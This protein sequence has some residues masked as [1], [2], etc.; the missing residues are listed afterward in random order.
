MWRKRLQ[1]AIDKNI[2][3][4]QGI[5]L[6]RYPSFILSN[7]PCGLDRIPVFV[8]HDVTVGTLE[9]MLQFLADNHYVTL[10]ADEY[11]ERQIRG[12]K[13][14][15]REVV[16]TFDD[17]HKSLY[18]VAFPALKRFGFK[19]VAYIVPGL[20]EEIDDPED[21]DKEG[22]PLCN[23][24]EIKEMHDS[25]VVDIQSHSMYH[26]TIWISPQVVDFMR[27]GMKPSFMYTHLA[28]MN[29]STERFKRPYEL[30]YG[31]PIYDWGYRFSET[32]AFRERPA[33]VQ[34]C[35]E[36]VTRHGGSDY[37]R[38]SDWRT[39]LKT[40]LMNARRAESGWPD[41][42]TEEEKRNAILKDFIDSKLEI[43]RHLPGKVVR[44][45]C[46][47]WFR[48]SALAIELSAEGGYIS[49]AWGSLLPKFVPKDS[50]LIHMVRF[51]PVYLWRL[52]GK[53][54]KSIGEVLQ[55]RMEEVSWRRSQYE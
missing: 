14:R 16:L 37:F 47:T 12:E 8:F 55:E 35:V 11:V 25:G 42:E 34:A 38:R 41:L 27:P 3:D 10:T 54:R 15:E 13:G 29:G 7:R 28:P 40:V 48:G 44:H 21:T 45:F 18:T 22:K 30:P 17:G 26:H 19:A 36:Y 9:P 4:I 43:E 39:G 33:V 51:S 49:N 31:T 32:P 24:K 50:P 1:R 52:P 53:G 20:T 5:L 23:W 2:E 46:Y 6:W